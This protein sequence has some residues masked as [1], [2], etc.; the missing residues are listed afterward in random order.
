MFVFQIS[1]SHWA[2]KHGEEVE[3]PWEDLLLHKVSQK[4]IMT[5]WILAWLAKNGISTH[6]HLLIIFHIAPC[7]T[8]FP[9]AVTF[10]LRAKAYRLGNITVLYPTALASLFAY[11]H[12]HTLKTTAEM[13]RS[14]TEGQLWS[15]K[16]CLT[17]TSSEL[18]KEH[19]TEGGDFGV[20]LGNGWS[21]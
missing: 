19:P 14:V 8:L 21:G 1:S 18:R 16:T 17:I 11:L 12:L 15:S 13:N 20:F 7:S 3:V 10:R 2:W 9:E 6:A 5:M 4:A